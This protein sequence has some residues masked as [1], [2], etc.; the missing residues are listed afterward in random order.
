MMGYAEEPADFAMGRTVDE[1]RTGDLARR[2]A[3]GMYEIVG[4]SNRFAK[5]FGLRIDLDRVER[6]FADEDLEVRAVEC[7]AAPRAL[8]ARRPPG[9]PRARARDVAVRAPDPRDP[10]ARH[11]GVP[12]H[13]ERQAR[14][15][16]TRAP[17]RTA[18]TRGI[19]SRRR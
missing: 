16:G 4:R 10:R 18:R 3:D 15:C 14:Q 17:R 6:L 13:V 12:A 8:R 5:I 2:R 1:L 7:D 19:A 11:R 9:A